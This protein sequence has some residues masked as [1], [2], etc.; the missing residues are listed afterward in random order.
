MALSLSNSIADGLTRWSRKI[1]DLGGAKGASRRR[2]MGGKEVLWIPL[3]VR[4]MQL[5]MDGTERE[6][7]FLIKS[8]VGSGQVAKKPLSMA[9]QKL[10]LAG[11]P[12]VA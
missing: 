11:K 5:M 4:C 1:D 9:L 12:V 7:C 3:G 2:G 8:L 6:R 10:D